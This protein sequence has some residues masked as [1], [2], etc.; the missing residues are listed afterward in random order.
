MPSNRRTLKNYFSD[1]SLPS[2]SHFEDLVDSTLNLMDDGFARTAEN[3]VE[4]S[5]VGDGNRLISFFEDA[6][7]KTDPDWSITCEAK[8]T[9]LNFVHHGDVESGNTNDPAQ[10]KELEVLTLSSSGKIGVRNQNPSF[11]LDV[12]GTIRSQARVGLTG[13]V[14]ADGGW[15]PI[16][17]ELDGCHALEIV[18]G[19]GLAGQK[20]GRYAL[21]HAVALNA[22]N[23]SGWLFNLFGRKNRIRATNAWYLSRADRMKLRWVPAGPA[24]SHAYQLEIRT[25]RSYG[26]D[27]VVRYSVTELWPDPFMN[28]SKETGGSSTP[29]K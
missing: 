9:S 20:K 13:T 29:F 6:Q 14:P 11:D 25:Y 4:I 10:E 19:V 16:T 3:G 22:Y 12:A 28:N 17:G 24:Y 18:A 5:L 27:A 21:L 26:E 2:Q 1:G 8:S 7:A 23:P 15:Y